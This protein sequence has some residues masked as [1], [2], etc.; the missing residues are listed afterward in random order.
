MYSSG[1]VSHSRTNDA[2]KAGIECSITPHSL[3]DVLLHNLS[4]F[5]WIIGVPALCRRCFS[6]FNGFCTARQLFGYSIAHSRMNPPPT[7]V[8]SVNI[9]DLKLSWRAIT[10]VDSAFQL[11]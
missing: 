6:R 7:P 10:L 3:K 1:T 4:C 8:P 11:I 9:H 5:S 2:F